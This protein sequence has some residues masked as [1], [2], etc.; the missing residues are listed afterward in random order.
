MTTSQ[1]TGTILAAIGGGMLLARA[2]RAR[3][4]IDFAGMTIV[5]TGGSRG[6]G[7][8][9]ARELAS[10]GAHVVLMARDA[11]ELERARADIES[12]GGDA[13]AFVCDIRNRDDV[14]HTI[15]RIV[16]HFGSIDV[17][18]NDAGIIQA[19]PLSHMAVAD[20]EDAMATHFWGPLFTILP[21][22]PY[23][24][25]GGARRIVNISSI[26]GRI[27]VP[28]MLPYSASKFALTGLSE[29]LHVELAREGIRV[30][31]VSPGLMR[32]GSTYNAR[33]K[34]RHRSEFAWFHLADSV[35]GLSIDATRA[36]HQIVEACRHG[37]AELTITFLAR[38]AVLM[39]TACPETMARMMT[40]TNRLL[41]SATD[42]SGNE[43]RS[44]WQ[45]TSRWVPSAVTAL[46]DRASADNN[47][48]GTDP[49]GALPARR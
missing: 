17:L 24:R 49:N 18:I 40:M 9:I 47:E 36:A 23:M 38:L 8:V 42:A 28:H 13:S 45:S 34:G 1:R 10:E 37:D 44:G 6:L 43:A 21:V 30:T 5:I 27:A 14:N 48:L 39:N 3:K 46:S 32:T 41:P 2:F 33:F 15:E 25:Q 16:G 31:T 4:A 11:E 7:L 26:G 22:L 35:P 19:G 29:G 20:F 12:R